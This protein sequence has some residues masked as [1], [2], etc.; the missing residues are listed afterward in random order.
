MFERILF[1]C[2]RKSTKI[3]SRKKKKVKKLCPRTLVLS[4]NDDSVA[5]PISVLSPTDFQKT[6]ALNIFAIFPFLLN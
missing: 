6:P 4:S 5:K 3:L 2:A 1:I